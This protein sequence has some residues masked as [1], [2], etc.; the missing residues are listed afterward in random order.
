MNF[1]YEFLAAVL[2]VWV[3]FILRIDFLDDL[4]KV[5]IF[6]GI[7]FILTIQIKISISHNRW[8]NRLIASITALIL[9]IVFPFYL[10]YELCP[11]C[12]D[13]NTTKAI[14]FTLPLIV[15]FWILAGYINLWLGYVANRESRTFD[16]PILANMGI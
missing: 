15:A 6:F 3:A 9:A 8:L 10:I 11:S 4:G 2:A 14:Q 1:D 12:Y 5:I 7:V 13:F 16:E